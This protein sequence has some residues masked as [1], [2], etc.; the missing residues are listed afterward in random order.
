MSRRDQSAPKAARRQSAR[1]RSH[2]GSRTSSAAPTSAPGANRGAAENDGEHEIDRAL[3]AEIARFDLD[4]MMGK[5]RAGDGGDGG[6][7][8]ERAD[9]DQRWC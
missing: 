3:E 4:V 1:K 9:F 6:A 8:A 7:E 2:S 5:E